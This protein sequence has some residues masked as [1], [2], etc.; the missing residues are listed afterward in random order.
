MRHFG[1]LSRYAAVLVFGLSMMA[2]SASAS[3]EGNPLAQRAVSIGGTITEIL[4]ALGAEERIIAVDSTS[5]FPSEA[6]SKPDVGYMRALSAEG[7]L[8]QKPDLIIAEDGSGPPPVLDILNASEIPMVIIATPARGDAIGQKIRDVGA[9]VGLEGKAEVLATKT[10]AELKKLSEEIARLDEPPK[11]VLF[12]LSLA[13]G[14]I[15]A[16]GTDTEAAEIIRLA[17]GINAASEI[18]GYKPL[19]DEAVI[20]AR[21][22]VILTMKRGNHQTSTEEVFGLPAFQTTPAANDKALVSMDGL[23]LLG[24]GPRTPSAVRELFRRLYPDGSN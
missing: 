8:A 14:R 12:V 22:D 19:S 6:A 11:R 21:P 3:S 23:L 1:S 10:E 9:A 7:I 17:G 20:A 18:S 24:F 16:G 13:N 5:S 4:Y 15:M 2:T